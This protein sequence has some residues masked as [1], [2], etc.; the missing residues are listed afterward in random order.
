MKKQRL[1]SRKLR[2]PAMGTRRAD[3]ATLLNPQNLALT[4]PSRGGRKV[5]IVR[6]RTRGHGVCSLFL[7]DSFSL[8]A[9]E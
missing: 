5:G 3:H 8:G 1:L 2:L 9:F 6:L 4:S 7:N